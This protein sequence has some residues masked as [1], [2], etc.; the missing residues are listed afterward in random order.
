MVIE[1]SFYLGVLYVGGL[2]K[3]WTN[4]EGIIISRDPQYVKTIDLNGKKPQIY[5]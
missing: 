4:Q 3:E 1:F 5:L 2:G